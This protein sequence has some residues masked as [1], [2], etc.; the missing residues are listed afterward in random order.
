MP[1]QWIPAPQALALLSQ[2]SEGADFRRMLLNRV[3]AGALKSRA[4]LLN[5]EGDS[6]P[7]VFLKQAFWDWDRYSETEERW[8]VGDFSTTIDGLRHDA[9][10]VAFD[11]AGLTEMLPPEQGPKLVR[12]VSVA[13]DED[14]VT[15]K[16]ARAFMYNELDA[17][18]T[19]AG[20]LLLDQCRLGF[21]AARAVLR[22]QAEDDNPDRWST[23]EREWDIPLWFWESFTGRDNSSQDWERGVFAGKGRAPTGLCLLTLSG[24]YFS[25]ASLDAMLPPSIQSETA[26]ITSPVGRPLAAFWDDLWC[27]VWGKI[28]RAELIP[29]RQAEVERAMLDWANDNGYDLSETAAKARARKLFAEYRSEGKN[30]NQ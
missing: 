28:F 11:L 20:E 13:G 30:P 2:L 27:A 12:R 5:I 19:K 17:P 3:R 23:E 24:V 1:P 9:I 29:A 8:E 10:G 7:L 4:R 18:P 25:R 15:A 21:V 26:A 22:R 14:W 16:A 6:R